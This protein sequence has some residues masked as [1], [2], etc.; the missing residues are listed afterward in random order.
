MENKVSDDQ[1]HLGS[2]EQSSSDG[3]KVLQDPFA[4]F[5]G[6]DAAYINQIYKFFFW[7][8]FLIFKLQNFLRI[9]SRKK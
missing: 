9:L 7:D 2:Y 4:L 5:Y 8:M 3:K 1:N 6:A